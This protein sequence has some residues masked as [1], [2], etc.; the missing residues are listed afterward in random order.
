MSTLSRVLLAAC[1]A[2]LSAGG[3][4]PASAQLNSPFGRGSNALSK[5]EITLIRQSIR[6]V[7]ETYK[8]GATSKWQLDKTGRSGEAVLKKTFERDGMR[9]AVITHE[10]LTGQGNP[11]TAPVCK[12]PNGKW[13]LTF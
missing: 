9:C 6:Q 4:V 3:A 5:E 12:Y 10:F 1:I 7:L 11:Y 8:V 2:V 13:L